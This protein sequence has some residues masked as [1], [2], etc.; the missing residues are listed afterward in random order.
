VPNVSYDNSN[1]DIVFCD[2]DNRICRLYYS[3]S[4]NIFHY[5]ALTLELTAKR[6]MQNETVKNNEELATQI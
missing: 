5:A 6:L 2:E 1:N 4:E 3:W